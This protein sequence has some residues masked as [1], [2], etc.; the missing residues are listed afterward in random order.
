MSAAELELWLYARPDKERSI[1]DRHAEVMRKLS[2]VDGPL[3]FMG[4]HIPEAP[5]V[6]DGLAAVFAVKS[7]IRGLRIIG[8]Y[9]FRGEKYLYKD[10]AR[11]DEHLRYKFKISNKLINYTD[12][13]SVNYPKVIEAFGSYRAEV[14]FDS[15]PY[16]YEDEES[17]NTFYKKLRSDENI[18]FN[19]RN[20]IF[21][22]NPAQFWDAELCH[23]ALGFG[24][25]EVIARLKGACKLAMPL[26]DGVYVVFNDDPEMTYEEYVEMNNII[27]PI[28][29]LL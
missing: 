19:G 20:N 6:G 23:R 16:R 21:T 14:Y 28:L 22:I 29:G 10:K 7:S 2:C 4:L 17:A 26:L 15:Y 5:D 27:K 18:D 24:P 1:E 9:V 11:F 3:G 13:L 25:E 12:I 8:D